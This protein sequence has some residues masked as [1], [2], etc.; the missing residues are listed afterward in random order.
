MRAE[1]GEEFSAFMA[2]RWPALVRFGYGLTGDA[3]AAGDLAREALARAWLAW[4]L[5]RR[6]ADPEN[7]V[8]RTMLARVRRSRLPWLGPAGTARLAESRQQHLIA[9][10]ARLPARQRAVLTLRY[11]LGL[12]VGDTALALGWPDRTIRRLD[13]RALA[14][15]GADPGA[16]PDPAAIPDPA[17]NAGADPAPNAG[18]EAASGPDLP[19]GDAELVSRLRDAIGD[20][21]LAPAPVGAVLRRGQALGRAWTSA[22]AGALALVV[23]IG[24][25]GA[26]SARSRHATRRPRHSA[27]TRTHPAVTIAAG[28][29]HGQ[30]WQLVVD[31]AAGIWCARVQQVSLACLGLAGYAHL[32]GLASLSGTAVPIAGSEPATGPPQWNAV[33]GVVRSDVTSVLVTMSD[34]QTLRLRPVTAAG[35]HWV[36]LIYWPSAAQVVRVSAYSGGNELGVVLPFI[37]SQTMPGTYYY[38]WLHQGP[39][40]PAEQ[41]RVIAGGGTGPAAWSASILAGPWGYCAVQQLPIAHGLRQACWSP[42]VLGAGARLLT[43]VSAPGGASTWLVGQARPQAA[44]LLLDLAGGGRVRVPVIAVSGRSFYALRFSRGQSVASWAAYDAAGHRLYGG[45]GAPA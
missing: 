11:W 16:N 19:P 18:A 39:K 17:P 1:S 28:T 7:H 12:S 40:G 44:Y 13:E 43:R 29:M 27:P 24:L 6:S 20:L 42:Q 25:A 4:P 9:A 35:N 10:L 2:G 31:S 41:Q 21:R 38:N 14:R 36:G 34:G 8:R 32:T 30:Q 15:L 26:F 37:G 23:V 22:A 45:R 5:V 3:D 33:V